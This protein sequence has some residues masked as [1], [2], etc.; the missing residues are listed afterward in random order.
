MLVFLDIPLPTIRDS[1]LRNMI[2]TQLTY[3]SKFRKHVRNS[4]KNLKKLP[5]KALFINSKILFHRVMYRVL[6]IYHILN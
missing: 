5:F 6:K 2:Q 1:M 3:L 4:V